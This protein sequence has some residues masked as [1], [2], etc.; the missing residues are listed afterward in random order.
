MPPQQSGVMTMRVALAGFSHETNTYSNVP[1]TYE[2]FTIDRG[3]EIVRRHT[4]AHST[5]TG[6]LEVADERGLDLVPLLKAQTGPIGM[7]TADAFDRIVGEM[8]GLIESEGPWDAVLLANHGAAVSEQYPDVDGEIA[9]R[10][11]AIVGPDIPIGMGMDLHGNITRRMIEHTTACVFYRENP[12]IDSRQRG[13]ECAEIIYRTVKGEVKP[14]QWLETPPLV[15]SIVRQYTGMEPLKTLMDECEALIRQPGILSASV[16]QGYPYADVEEMGMSFLVVADR[17]LDLAREEA[18]RLA[19]R[20]WE[21]RERFQG[22][23]LSPTQALHHAMRAARGP[24]VLMDV[25]DNIG[26]G[27]S[28]DSTVLLAEARRLG[29]TSLL[30]TLY[31]PEAV[32]RCVRAGVGST[33]TLEVG[34][35]TDDRHGRPIEVTGNVRLLH[36]GKFE[37]TRPTHGGAR[38]F[39]QGL[40]AVLDT[41]DEHTLVLN[42]R[43]CGNTSIEQMYSLGVRPEGYKVVIAKGVQSPRPAYEP[44]ASEIVLV[45]TP[46]VT[47][48][49]LSFF[50]YERRRRPLYPFEPDARYAES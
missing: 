46:G 33:L 45:N 11:R 7:I 28:A 20:A 16:I 41:E 29:A 25:G 40:T 14:V 23:T 12:H 31:D 39:D 26:G 35:K 2:R 34:A 3:E 5:V 6:F 42:S 19:R 17:D 27:S 9:A 18:R 21:M 36:E 47:T 38:Y 44:I 30:Q 22:G 8:L 43:R 24:V 13:R 37:D 48:A 50:T 1:A 32:Q 10:V 49:D 4:G 15:I